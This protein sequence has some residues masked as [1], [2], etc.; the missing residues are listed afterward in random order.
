M[1]KVR[2]HELAKGLNLQ[3][4]ELI[5]IISSLGVEVKSHMSIL[6]GKDLEIVIGHFRKIEA[7]KIRKMKRILLKVKTNLMKRKIL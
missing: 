5:N 4:K 7:E 6:E 2:V 1:S 3:S